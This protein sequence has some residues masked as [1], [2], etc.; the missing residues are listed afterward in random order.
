[1]T[2]PL[3]IVTGTGTGIGKTHVARALLVAWGQHARVVGFK[4]IET[5]SATE[6]SDAQLL[7]NASTFH[8]KPSPTYAL[9][10]PVSPHLAARVA[11]KSI[12][13][14][15]IREAATRLQEEADGVLVELAGGLF[16]PLARGLTNAT[17]AT[18]LEPSLLALVAPDR[19]GVLHDVGAANRAAVS[20][21]LRIDV[22]IL[23]CPA[24]T[25]ASTGTNA[26]ELHYV[27]AV[28]HVLELPRAPVAILAARPDVRDLVMRVAGP[29]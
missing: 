9:P 16:T 13:V 3:I 19:L 21:R 5:G 10:R 17:L 20:E 14:A 24:E 8:V 29:R 22:V 15:P 18:A 12:E 2:C 6:P 25:D 26:D 28:P 11:G 23:N 1:V 27:V 4:P 7:A